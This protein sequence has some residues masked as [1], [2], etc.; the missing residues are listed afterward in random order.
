MSFCSV[1]IVMGNIV[2]IGKTYSGQHLKPKQVM[3]IFCTETAFHLVEVKLY[4]G[5]YA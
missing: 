4:S 5:Y 2:S 3:C 1:T